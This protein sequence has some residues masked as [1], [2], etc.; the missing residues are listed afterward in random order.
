M[1]IMNRRKLAVLLTTFTI[2]LIPLLIFAITFNWQHD[3]FYL[4]GLFNGSTKISI[5]VAKDWLDV[6]GAYFFGSVRFSLSYVLLLFL[7]AIVNL[8][9]LSLLF[10]EAIISLYRARTLS[11]G[12]RNEQDLSN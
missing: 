2:S 5:N 11:Q 9:S 4:S 7:S 12:K 6:Y 10:L 1:L 3:G 8:I